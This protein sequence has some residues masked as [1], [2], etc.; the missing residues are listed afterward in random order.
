MNKKVIYYSIRNGGDGSAYPYFYESEELAEWDQEHLTE[1][2]G[3]KLYRKYYNRIR[4]R[5]YSYNE[6]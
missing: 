2:W 5:S 6:K 4:F 3:G 1:G